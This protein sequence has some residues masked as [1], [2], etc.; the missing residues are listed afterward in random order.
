[1]LEQICLLKKRILQLERLR[2]GTQFSDKQ[3]ENFRAT[4]DEP[5][6]ISELESQIDEFRRSYIQY[7]IP[8]D[9]IELWEY[10]DYSVYTDFNHH[11]KFPNEIENDVSVA[12]FLEKFFELSEVETNETDNAQFMLEL[13]DFNN[14]AVYFETKEDLEEFLNK[15]SPE[16]CT[17]FEQEN[18]AF[19]ETWSA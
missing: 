15:Y 18:G 6:T 4:F 16:P 9:I 11:R 7:Y 5:K 3:F 1:M 10:C 13:Y 2:Y 19:V 17:C 14:Y 8:E 12:Y